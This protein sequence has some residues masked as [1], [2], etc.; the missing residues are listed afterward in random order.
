MVADSLK[1]NKQKAIAFLML[2]LGS[3]LIPVLT[4]FSAPFIRILRKVFGPWAYWLEGAVLVSAFLLLRQYSTAL[5]FASFWMTLGVY[6]ECEFRGVSWRI[7]SAVSILAGCLVV[8]LATQLANYTIGPDWIVQLK[9]SANEAIVTMKSVN[10]NIELEAE[11]LLRSIPAVIISLLVITLGVG[12][13]FETRLY[14]WLKI[15][16]VRVASQLK[17][18]EF[19]VPDFF[20][21]FAI[22][23]I[24]FSF[25]DFGITS[26]KWIGLNG[27]IISS[28]FYFFQGLAVLEVGLTYIRSGALIRF[29]A[30]FMFIFQLPIVLSV[31]GLADYWVEFRR[32]LRTVKPSKTN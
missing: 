7:S 21:W 29:L 26:L 31:L 14:S 13:I 5:V 10:P 2:S 4:F 28:V 25:Q 12:L 20:I 6:A 17:L 23:S 3:A 22:S 27:F 19:K 30:Y 9:A 8:A 32:R 1:T 11:T 15:P 24:L 16:R 18:I